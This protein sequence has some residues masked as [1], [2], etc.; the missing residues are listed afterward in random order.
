MGAGA[1]V[2]A[3]PR[4]SA[5]AVERCRQPGACEGR[6]MAAGAAAGTWVLILSLWGELL[7]LNPPY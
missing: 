4:A 5:T 7:P 1:G 2:Q 3:P 6:R